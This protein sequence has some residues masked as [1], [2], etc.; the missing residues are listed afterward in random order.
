M[1]PGQESPASARREP[2]TWTPWGCAG[3]PW[4]P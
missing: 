3:S 2:A 4:P 1:T